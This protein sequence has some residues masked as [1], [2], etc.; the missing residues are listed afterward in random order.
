VDDDCDGGVDEALGE[1]ACGLGACAQIVANCVA[2]V[3]TICNP[4]VG[5]SQELCDNEADDDCDGLTDCQDTG[6]CSAAAWCAPEVDMTNWGFE[7][8]WTPGDPVPD[9]EISWGIQS[10]IIA[11]RSVAPVHSGAAACELT[12]TSPDQTKQDFAQGYL[13]PVTPNGQVT[14]GVWVRDDEAAGRARLAVTFHDAAK[15]NLGNVFATT[16]T[17]DDPGWVHVT[18]TFDIPADAA[19]VRGFIRLYDVPASWDGN[20]TINLDDWSMSPS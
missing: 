17:N 10:S 3:P 4:Y 8:P 15:L 11:L 13:T 1:A 18:A 16:Y 2:G 12:W 20:A 7:E 5:A 19:F 6:D 9:F 14:F